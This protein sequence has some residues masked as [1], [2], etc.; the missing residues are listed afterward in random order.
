MARILVVDDYDTNRDLFKTVLSDPDNGGHEVVVADGGESALRELATGEKFDLALVDLEM[1][2]MTGLELAR[3][4]SK[5]Y[6]ALSI[7]LMSG[8]DRAPPEWK[9]LF[10]SK[11]FHLTALTGVVNAVLSGLWRSTPPP[12][13]PTAPPP[14]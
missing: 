4:I 8:F 13:P 9:G 3:E 7:A 5:Q 6:P 1:P 12:A 10:I 11:P 2:T 14:G